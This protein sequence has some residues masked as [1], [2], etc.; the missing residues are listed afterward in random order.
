M[1]DTI[2]LTR[3]ERIVQWTGQ[4]ARCEGIGRPDLVEICLQALD[5]LERESVIRWEVPA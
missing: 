5:D 2:D 4:L 3:E 1:N